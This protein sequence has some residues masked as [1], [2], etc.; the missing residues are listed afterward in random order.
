[1]NKQIQHTNSNSPQ[2]PDE[3]KKSPL[4]SF[5]EEKDNLS[6]MD[7][8]KL[9]KDIENLINEIEE[10][11]EK[12]LS[13]TQ[14]KAAELLEKKKIPENIL[15]EE[16]NKDELIQSLKE[17]LKQVAEKEEKEQKISGHTYFDDLTKAMGAH[18]PKTMTELLERARFEKKES[19]IRSIKSKKNLFFLIASIFLITISI[20]LFQFLGKKKEKKFFTKKSVHSMVFADKNTGINLDK[21]NKEEIKKAITTT[22]EKSIE[23]GS[24]H[25]IYYVGKDELG[26]FRKLGIKQVFEKMEITPP[27]GFY[28]SVK[29]DFM[30]GVYNGGKNYPFLVI[31]TISYD[32]AFKTMHAWEESMIDD[33]GVFLDLPEKAYNRSLL[34]AGFSNDII[35][36]HIVRVMRYLPREVDAQGEIDEIY[37]NQNQ[38][39]EEVN[40]QQ[41]SFFSKIIHKISSKL[42]EN[43]FVQTAYAEKSN[44]VCHPFE[45]ECYDLKGNQVP[46]DPSD[47]TILCTKKID[48][49]RTYGKEVTDGNGNPIGNYVC[50]K[51]V[52]NDETIRN[53]RLVNQGE[54]DLYVCYQALYECYDKD[55][56]RIP[57]PSDADIQNPQNSCTKTPDYNTNP[58]FTRDPQYI[59]NPQYVCQARGNGAGMVRESTYE[60]TA[61]G[62][63][64]DTLIEDNIWDQLLKM[65]QTESYIGQKCNL[66]RTK[67]WYED[68]QT[69]EATQKFLK[70]IG[71]MDSSSPTGKIDLLTQEIIRGFQAINGLE[72]TGIIDEQTHSLM[73]SIAQTLSG[74][75]KLYG[76][77]AIAAINDYLSGNIGL[78]AYNEQVQ[79]L[80]IFLYGEGYPIHQINGLFDQDTMNAL[81]DF[82]KDHGLPETTDGKV[83]KETLDLINKTIE[84][85]GY[86][87]SGF[88]LDG[89]KLIGFGKLEGKYGPGTI[90][91]GEDTYS[92][93]LVKGDIVLLYTFLDEHTLLI[94]RDVPV[95]RE[96]IKRLS[97]ENIFEKNSTSS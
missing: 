95:I 87:G 31:Q 7:L 49:T 74:D 60:E 8:D 18:N 35:E 84:E 67:C 34:E 77:S 28:E 1:M 61:G 93:K 22:I 38:K 46:R 69:I 86:L 19:S 24:L 50:T 44:I 36:N 41:L 51:V 83:D 73:S 16:E 45:W 90:V 12:K 96:I 62:G 43:F 52:G 94:A 58:I 30:H 10:E 75:V 56:I 91:V 71:L 92:D 11:K 42:K 64:Q 9:Q 33:I 81:H 17:E 78:G 70:T 54:S 6:N 63:A 27:E 57:S 85:N 82:Q 37:P 3:E 47:S 23:K 2:N 48:P 59:H 13:P 97:L 66:L 72:E 88:K 40:P 21:L 89:D 55:G 68:P 14:Q 20:F 80:Q 32:N 39:N 79:A 29:K 53:D 65:F 26:N 76:G 25:N 15:H 5:S 4:Q